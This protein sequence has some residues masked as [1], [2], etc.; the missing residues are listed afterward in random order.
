MDL[1][2]YRLFRR[3]I[4]NNRLRRGLKD[5]EFPHNP[6]T[7]IRNMPHEKR[8][9]L[10]R[11]KPFIHGRL[12]KFF[13]AWAFSMAFWGTYYLR[14]KMGFQQFNAEVTKRA[15]RKTVPFVQAMEDIRFTAIQERNYM[16]L[17]AICDV[18]NPDLFEVYRQRYNQEDFFLSYIRGSTAKNYYDGR[19][20][21][22][23]WWDM[24]TYRKPEDESYL[25][26]FQEQSIHG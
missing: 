22:S 25:V 13:L 8:T 2:G 14:A 4:R 15:L 24:H 7:R 18:E 6:N 19:Y 12:P 21:T 17:K 26:G 20:G 5:F 9:R 3:V 10:F 11:D 16:I 1:R 23:R